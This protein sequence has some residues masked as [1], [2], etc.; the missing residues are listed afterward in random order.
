MQ[1][2]KRNAQRGE[3]ISSGLDKA[4]E[5][6]TKTTDAFGIGKDVR[7]GGGGQGQGQGGGGG[8]SQDSNKVPTWVWITGGVVVLGLGIFAIYKFR[9]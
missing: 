3:K 5:I 7:G 9:Q 4:L 1:K 8:N 2:A 6:F